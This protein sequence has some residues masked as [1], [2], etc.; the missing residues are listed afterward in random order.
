MALQQ[1]DASYHLVHIENVKEMKN[2][3]K[4]YEIAG[5]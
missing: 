5:L 4:N 3:Y 1:N 2:S